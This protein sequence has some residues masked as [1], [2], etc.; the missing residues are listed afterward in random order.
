[1]SSSCAKKIFYITGLPIFSLKD[2][3]IK[4]ADTKG[5]NDF[6]NLLLETNIFYLMLN[7][8]KQWHNPMKQ[9]Q[10]FLKSEI[11]LD[12][13][14]SLIN[15]TTEEVVKILANVVAESGFY[16]YENYIKKIN[17]LWP[18]IKTYPYFLKTAIKINPE[19]AINIKIDIHQSLITLIKEPKNEDEELFVRNIT[20]SKLAFFGSE[21]FRLVSA[22]EMDE[23]LYY[24]QFRHYEMPNNYSVNSNIY[25]ISEFSY[26]QESPDIFKIIDEEIVKNPKIYSV[27]LIEHL[28]KI[29]SYPSKMKAEQRLKILLWLCNNYTNFYYEY[30]YYNPNKFIIKYKESH[31]NILFFKMDIKYFRSQFFNP[32]DNETLF[33]TISYNRYCFIKLIGMTGAL[34]NVI[35]FGLGPFLIDF[36]NLIF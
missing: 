7:S 23:Y 35:H 5:N 2:G 15:N 21:N 33:P 9:F 11:T 10:R 32:I 1:M 12:E 8:D 26:I 34:M 19:V 25:D 29:T 24:S 27:L 4:L 31:D 16:M 13:L 14:L 22:H 30:L 6:C 36:F 18:L 3:T 28:F 20:E 17:E